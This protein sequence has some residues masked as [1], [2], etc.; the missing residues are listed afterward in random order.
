[1]VR[2]LW[3]CRGGFRVEPE[4]GAEIVRHRLD[5]VGG[6]QA[7]AADHAVDRGLPG[8]EI[9][10]PVAEHGVGVALE[11]LG[12][13]HIAARSWARRTRLRARRRGRN[14]SYAERRDNKRIF[15]VD[16]LVTFLPAAK[17]SRSARTAPR[18]MPPS[19]RGIGDRAKYQ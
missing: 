15:H 9:L 18:R 11:A 16:S 8:A 6:P 5:L 1:M 3:L 19:A 14:Q 12:L 4:F 13:D 7:A 17:S 2:P 10:P